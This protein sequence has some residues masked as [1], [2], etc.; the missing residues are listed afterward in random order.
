MSTYEY[1]KNPLIERYSSREMSSIFSDMSKFTTWRKLWIALAKCEKDLGLNITDEQIK[2]LEE[3]AE[4]INFEDAIKFEKE[5]RHDV[6]S[7]VKAYGLQCPS[8]KGI[9]H[10]GATSAYVGDNTDV[11]LMKQALELTKVKL[12]N[13]MNNLAQFALQYKDMPALGYTHFQPA[14]LTTVGKRACL[15]L[16]DLLLDFE[17]IEYRIENLK[18]RGVK[19][20]TGTQA[21]FLK[22]FNGDHDKV[23]KLDEMVCKSM[24]IESK[25]T[26]TGQTYTRKQDY[27]VLSSLSSLAQSMHKMTND[28]RL[29]QNL[30]EVEEPFEKNQIGSS[31]MAYKRN[32]MRSERISSLSKYVMSQSL[33]PALIFSTQWFER[34][35]DDS[36]NRRLS[37]PEAFLGIDAILEIGI[38]VTSGLVV[39]ENV[40]KKH[41]NEELPFMATE[42]ILMEAVTRGGDRQ[43]LHEKI[44]EYSME[45]GERIKMQGLDNNLID[46][47]I[48]DP[49]FNMSK[50]E[51]LNIIDPAKFTGRAPEQVVDFITEEIMPAVNRCKEQLGMSVD[52]KV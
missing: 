34:T 19:G 44:R 33:N 17:E 3:N 39:Y 46:R 43:E 14:Q 52:L 4:N 6:M 36:A 26:I 41:V 51:I 31:A 25:F 40:I 13:L 11:L 16:Q 32:P 5:T 8:A 10:L 49:A 7:H 1:Y 24:G 21:S 35:L 15:W 48:A 29:L 18:M 50:E 12:A 27:L 22:L 45:V 23:K 2:E 42:N 37:I 28:L 47:I 20:T 38:N 9:I 30:K